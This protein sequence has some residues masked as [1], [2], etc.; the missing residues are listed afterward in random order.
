MIKSRE[1]RW[2]ECSTNGGEYA[3]IKDIDGKVRKKEVTRK[4]KT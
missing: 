1:M 3:C 2:G 4:T